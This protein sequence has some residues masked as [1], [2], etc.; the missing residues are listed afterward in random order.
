MARSRLTF[1]IEAGL[2][3]FPETGDIAV[4]QPTALTDISELPKQRV[5][6]VQGFYPDHQLL[7]DQDFRTQT[8]VK[9]VFGSALV[10]LPRSKAEGRAMIHRALA[11]TNGGPVVIDGQKTDGI[12]SILKACRAHGGHIG[13]VFSKAHGK[14]FILSGGDFSDWAPL[15]RIKNKDGF[16]T[17]AGVFSAD[18]IDRGSAALVAGLPVKLSGNVAD[19]GAGWGYLAHHILQK[20][21]VRE[22]HL[23]E[24][25]HAALECART[26]VSDPRAR[27]HWADARSFNVVSDFDHVVTNPPFHT[28]RVADPDLGRGFITA[29]A[30]LLSRRGVVWLVANRHLP[31]EQ[32]LSETFKEVTEVAGDKSFKVFR[33]RFP[34]PRKS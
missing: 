9:G 30:R 5:V 34:R 18:A 25:E 10:F 17:E 23:I 16:F 8:D 13:N 31:Y 1:A 20:D 4:F 11:I 32:H 29:A 22:C 21:G 14:I 26:N 6:A 12:D 27:F 2:V 28:S 3:E 24:A 33:A 19:L 7:T 15:G